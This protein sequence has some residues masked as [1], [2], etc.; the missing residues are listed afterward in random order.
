[1][2]KR[3]DEGGFSRLNRPEARV[4]ECAGFVYD[5]QPDL[6]L[7][8][9]CPGLFLGEKIHFSGYDFVEINRSINPPE[10]FSSFQTNGGR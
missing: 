4:A 6:Q 10:K 3:T 1:M 7:A 5:F 2:E 9:L 8:E